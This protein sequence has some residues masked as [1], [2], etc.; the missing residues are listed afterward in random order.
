MSI[1][2]IKQRTNQSAIAK[3]FFKE[4]TELASKISIK[5]EEELWGNVLSLKPSDFIELDNLRI[6]TT[7][8]R[9][10]FSKPRVKMLK[11]TMK[12]FDA[13]QFG[14]IIIVKKQQL[15]KDVY[16]VVEGQGRVLVAHAMGLTQVPYEEVHVD[17]L[18]DEA[19]L[20]ARQSDLT[21]NLTNWEKHRAILGMPTSRLHKQALDIN[22]FINGLDSV[23]YEPQK[24]DDASV[25]VS[26]CYA[27][28]KAMILR[29][30][31]DNDKPAGERSIEKST[32]VFQCLVDIFG[33][34]DQTLVM[35]A[36]VLYPCM[37]YVL[38]Y[39][40]NGLSRLEEKISDW[41]T[42]R[43]ENG[44][45]AT[46]EDFAIAIDLPRQK[47]ANDKKQCYKNIKRL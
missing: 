22:E 5:P 33:N 41:R 14:R 13:R 3:K 27:A 18:E 4:M 25:D 46:L 2:T 47:N 16:T 9:D 37:E 10:P 1:I 17:S 20:F 21:N 23:E 26:G 42:A 36:D 39:Q 19:T 40:R 32:G 31:Q 34:D 28:I 30:N 44:H 45:S 11:K 38:S 24:L 12:N 8:Q 7:I 15:G 29:E 35:R 6:D 43:L